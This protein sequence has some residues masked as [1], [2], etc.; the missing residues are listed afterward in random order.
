ME[1]NTKPRTSEG[2]EV[3]IRLHLK[4]N[5]GHIELAKLQPIHIQS[6]ESSTL[7]PGRATRTVRNVHTV[8]HEALEHAMRWGL[9]WRNP[10]HLAGTPKADSNEV[11]VPAADDFLGILES[12]SE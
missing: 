5:I 7:A 9:I 8:N 2:Y 11:K 6:V 4:P 10:A 1:A 12:S 3:I